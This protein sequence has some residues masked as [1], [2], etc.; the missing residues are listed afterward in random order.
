MHS[1]LKV[2]HAPS[3]LSRAGGDMP[4]ID[5]VTK[6]VEYLKEIARG[7]QEQKEVLFEKFIQPAFEQI[8]AIHTDYLRSLTEVHQN[9]QDQAVPMTK[10]LLEITAKRNELLWM[11]TTVAQGARTLLRETFETGVDRKRDFNAAGFKF[12][13]ALQDYLQ[14]RPNGVGRSRFSAIIDLLQHGDRQVATRMV[15]DILFRVEHEWDLVVKAYDNA[16]TKCYLK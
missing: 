8:S 1:P 4:M 2:R 15:G 7:Q 3:T 5:S 12:A 13:S 14:A 10:V 6:L 16:K 11:R 9:L